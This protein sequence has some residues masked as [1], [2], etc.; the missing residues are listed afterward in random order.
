VKKLIVLLIGLLFIFQACKKD[1]LPEQQEYDLAKG[2]FIINQ[3][4]F[5][6]ANASLSYFETDSKKLIN[7][8][9][10]GVNKIPL[11]DVAQSITLWEDK[12]FIVINNSG[13]VYCINRKNAQITGKISGLASPRNMLILNSQ[14]AYISDLYD[15][16]I[17]IVNPTTFELT[18]TIELNRSS[19]EMVLI[20][21]KAYVANYSAYSQ[22]LKND[23]VLVVDTETDKLVDTIKVG[24]EPNSIVADKDNNF[25]VL[26]SGGYLNEEFPT[27]WKLN[28]LNGEVL[29]TFTFDVL[30]SNPSGI[31]INGLGDQLFFM[32]KGVYSMSVSDE[33]LPEDPIIVPGGKF[34]YTMGIDPQNSDI[35]LSDAL[36]YTQ[37]GLV[38]RYDVSG[39]LSDS[40]EVGI[41]PGAFGFNY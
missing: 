16:Y 36:D 21:T 13:V 10:M 15:H 39:T 4:T 25:W 26:C 29:H 38:Y 14:K 20:G 40:L 24:I 7:N 30:Q 5:N 3:G 1:E 18:G 23:V 6:S 27:L 11:G 41:I 35:Y 9:F 8:L 2:V 32:N 31:K 12:A 37:N 17:S 28:G 34:F 22:D 19:E 33:S